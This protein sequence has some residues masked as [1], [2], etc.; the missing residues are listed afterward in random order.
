M[1]LGHYMRL[2]VDKGSCVVS[3]WSHTGFETQGDWKGLK[4]EPAMNWTY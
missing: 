1:V 3:C 2:L 4:C